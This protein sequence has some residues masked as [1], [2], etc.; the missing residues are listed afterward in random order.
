MMQSI[1]TAIYGVFYGIYGSVLFWPTDTLLHY[2]RRSSFSGIDIMVVTVLP[3]AIVGAGWWFLMH[4]P[5]VMMNRMFA[6][7][8]M[9]LGILITCPLLTMVN[10]TFA[11]GGFASGLTWRQLGIL[12][13]LFPLADIDCLTYDGTL[14][15]IGACMVGLIL[16]FHKDTRG[17]APGHCPPSTAGTAQGCAE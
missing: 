5:R 6:S 14:F 13:L 2:L 1:R 17:I 7:G 10:A 15:A 11:G 8:M 12:T 9:L 3:P 4:R 16:I